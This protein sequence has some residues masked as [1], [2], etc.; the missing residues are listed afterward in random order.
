MHR[1][2]G[3][4]HPKF[5]EGAGFSPFYPPKLPVSTQ[6]IHRKATVIHRI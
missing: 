5:P 4:F 6:V 1:K 3:F 2:A